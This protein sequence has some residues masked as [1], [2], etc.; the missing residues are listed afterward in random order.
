MDA[1]R[2][3][4]SSSAGKRFELQKE[5][6][7]GGFGAVWE[8]H[9]RKSGERVALK[10]LSRIAAEG[11]FRFKQEFRAAQDISHPNLVRLGELFEIG[12]GWF[13]SME[14]VE[15][16]D[17][18]EYTRPDGRPDYV[19]L[20]QSCVQALHGLAA[21]HAAG[22]VHRDIKP[23]N[24]RVTTEGRV[25]IL[26]FGMSSRWTG[27]GMSTQI[28]GGTA[29]YMAPEQAFPSPV[30]PAADM[31]ALGAMLYEALT[32]EVPFDGS[33]LRVLL[34]K[35]TQLPALPASKV[36]GI[37]P[38]LDVLC[39]QLMQLNPAARPTL[40]QAL[41]ALGAA[42]PPLAVQQ[43][44]MSPGGTQAGARFLGR[45]AELTVLEEARARARRGLPQVV[46]IEGESGLG[47]S[48]LLGHF[49]DEVRR[50]DA[51]T[52]I[53]QGR[54]HEFENVA[55]KGFDGIVDA[56]ARYLKRLGHSECEAFMP[57]RAALLPRLFPVLGRVPAIVGRRLGHAA[58]DPALLKR[59][60]FDALFDL[61]SRIAQR[62]PLILAIDDLH[63]SDLESIRTLTQN[64][65]DESAPGLLIVVTLRPLVELDPEL[66]ATITDLSTRAGAKDLVLGPLSHADSTRLVGE[67]LG[68]ALSQSVCDVVVRESAGHPMLLLALAQHAQRHPSSVASGLDLESVLRTRLKGLGREARSVLY[69]VAL[70][71][72]SLARSALA[73]VTGLSAN[74]VSTGLAEL[75]AEKL[76]KTDLRGG[77]ECFHPELR[78]IAAAEVDA[79][80]KRA[81]HRAL[82]LALARQPGTDAAVV[83]GHWVL[84]G[85]P[86]R[87][88][89][90]LLR[91]ADEA[92]VALGFA[93]AATLYRLSLEHAHSLAEQERWGIRVQLAHALAGA[94]V[95]VD[96]A[97]EYLACAE[98][99]SVDEALDLR[100]RAAHQLLRSL[101][102]DEGLNAA[103]ALLADIGVSAERDP[104][105][106]ALSLN[107]QRARLRLRGLAFVAR[108]EDQVAPELCRDL[109][110]MYSLITAW[111]PIDVVSGRALTAHFV[112]LALDAGGTKHVI[113]ALAAE[114]EQLCVVEALPQPRTNQVLASLE[115]LAGKSHSDYAKAR[116]LLA[117]GTVAWARF[118]V[119]VA[120]DVLSRADQLFAE[121]CGD[122]HWERMLAQSQFLSASLQQ[123][124]LTR[125]AQSVER[126]SS[127]AR[128]GG[129]KAARSVIAL[130]GGA[131]QRYLAQDDPDAAREEVEAAAACWSERRFSAIQASAPMARIAILS[132]R[133]TLATAA[134]AQRLLDE[135][136]PSAKAHGLLVHAPSAV[137]L[138][139]LKARVHLSTAL[140]T[141]GDERRSALALATREITAI[142]KHRWG[143][144]TSVAAELSA[145]VAC[146]AGQL[147]L[148]QRSLRV[149]LQNYEVAGF[150]RRRHLT[151]YMLGRLLQG[152]E[153]KALLDAAIAWAQREGIR[154]PARY[155]AMIDSLV[156]A[157]R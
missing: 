132:Y 141:G 88:V 73:S 125:H 21:L 4:A 72:V 2:V 150:G 93:R 67:V 13:F 80:A 148:A 30:G 38:E 54:C 116:A 50:D 28:P 27:S 25:V 90:T 55:H 118:D 52:V 34:E 9:D 33:P 59:Q 77:S 155:F 16:S 91:A 137:V 32:G 115:E 39:M 42:G 23:G 49:L 14:L 66:R 36:S 139:E 1:A 100:R 110:L 61:L 135:L 134:E 96:A 98:V 78:E 51:A 107:W 157:R 70:A 8:A 105:R 20:K 48:A 10:A 120:A 84:A 35:Q 92:L 29:A 56:L 122:A 89:P 121:R 97:R 106:A 130:L 79:S 6:G 129:D 22:I 43:S 82:A 76:L 103:E 3:L 123:G 53:L 152:E 19:R 60:A 5:L 18:L 127:E 74:E 37:P 62:R 147:E 17:F 102:I 45:E 81:L 83:A 12:G 138:L 58:A 133:D 117:R 47:K 15:G 124:H 112:R 114:A 94:G 46:L 144:Y 44:S 11:V 143:V 140:A 71:G 86:E 95:G 26:D 153:G 151:G 113:N 146:L 75:R 109:D 126:W 131:Y 101:K 145:H 63:F 104:R 24:I 108:G 40:E 85:E 7:A 111:T 87:A 128:A 99:A 31:Y 69:A 64:L 65:T 57:T 149:A 142:R 156:E 68:N 154:N 119:R 136:W 41:T